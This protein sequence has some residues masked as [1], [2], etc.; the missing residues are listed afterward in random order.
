MSYLK[1]YLNRRI[2]KQYIIVFTIIIIG[3]LFSINKINKINQLEQ[4]V[5]NYQTL[6][7]QIKIKN[8]S[9]TEEKKKYINDSQKKNN[10]QNLKILEKEKNIQQLNNEKQDLT[11]QLLH[12][13]NK[14]KE[15]SAVGIAPKNY[16]LPDKLS[17]GTYTTYK[18]KLVDVGEWL[19]TY[20]APNEAECSNN[21]GITASGKPIVPGQT[22]AIDRRYWEFGDKFYIE[23][24]GKVIAEDTG[25]A[26]KGRERFD[27]AVLSTK[28]SD[29]GSFR[30]RVFKIVE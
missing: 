9:L 17:Q 24:I 11:N 16:I 13:E 30:A 8:L 23:G 4:E 29:S 26:I 20:Y 5:K 6:Y 1:T 3:T 7:K 2:K 18:E 22:I 27:F 12:F 21:M 10:E 28:I 25:S 15:F 14:I 19:G